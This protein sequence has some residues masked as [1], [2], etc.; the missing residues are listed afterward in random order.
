MDKDEMKHEFMQV[1]IN[2]DYASFI[3]IYIY[4]CVC[5]CVWFPGLMTSN[6]SWVI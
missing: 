3:Y 2:F 4:V 5:V 1:S 6:F